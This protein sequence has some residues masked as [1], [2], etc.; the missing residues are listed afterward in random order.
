MK[1]MP[2]TEPRSPVRAMMP[3]C[4]ARP[5]FVLGTARSGTTWLANLLA[6]HPRIAAVFPKFQAIS[7]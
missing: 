1:A 3:A 4:R 2:V 5:V 6:D 7:T